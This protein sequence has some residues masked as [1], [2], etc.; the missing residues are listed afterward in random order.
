MAGKKGQAPRV[1][2]SQE[3]FD[4]ICLLIA[5]GGSLRDICA[6]DA[7]PD[8]TTF[9]K[10]RKRT[11]ELQSQYDA[12]CVDRE[13]VYF[14]QIITIADECRVGEKKVTKAN[15]DVEVTEIDM[16]ERARVQID[17]RK[18]CLARMNRKKYGDKVET[19]HS[20]SIS[21]DPIQLLLQQVEGSM[22]KPKATE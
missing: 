18:W 9:N 17:A 21:M 12:A 22:F 11:P 4:T 13:E 19:E 6:L 20:G 10:W 3:L 16:I 2:F 7:M 8:R 14:E 5:A 15:G 1:E